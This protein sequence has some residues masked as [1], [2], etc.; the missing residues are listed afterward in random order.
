M[1]KISNTDLYPQDPNISLEDYVIGTNGNTGSNLRTQTFPVLGLAQIIANYIGNVG[2]NQ[3]NIGREKTFF[4]VGDT[5]LTNLA[6][7]INALP[8]FTISQTEDFWFKGILFSSDPGSPRNS[9]AYIANLRLID[10]GK[11]DYGVAGTVLTAANL[12]VVSTETPNAANVLDLDNTVAISY[13][14]ITS[15]IQDWLNAQNPAITIQGQEDGYVLFQGTIDAVQMDYLWVGTSGDY[16]VGETPS[17]SIDFQLL[18]AA[19]TI[20]S[21]A[22]GLN[23]TLAVGNLSTL[24]IRLWNNLGTFQ[25]YISYDGMQLISPTAYSVYYAGALQ[26]NSDNKN[27]IL[28]PDALFFSNGTTNKQLKLGSIASLNN[29]IYQFP[30][31]NY[32]GGTPY[33]LATTADDLRPYKVFTALISQSGTADPT[34]I[35]LENTLGQTVTATRFAA[36]RY[37][38]TVGGGILSGNK[39]YFSITND[40]NNRN[41][42]IMNYD[43]SLGNVSNIEIS[44]YYIAPPYIDGPL[45]KTPL[46]IRVY[47]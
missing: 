5:S 11:G 13:G 30:D 9:I 42:I 36:G 16:G 34:L 21:S 33:T 44:T 39:T 8:A 4:F 43:S 19:G 17:T 20:S 24:P 38:L 29:S 47:N 31:K 45:D 7:A 6:L 25:N 46:E 1:P 40:N 14:A 3:D 41:V 2:A 15:P 28:N 37:Y 22:D 10:V 18:A 23:E 27:A 32:N 35:V 26:L 12:Q